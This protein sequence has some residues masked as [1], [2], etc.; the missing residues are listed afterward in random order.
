[1]SEPSRSLTR[2][3]REQRAYRLVLTTA[4]L[5]LLT[6]LAVIAAIIGI[7]GGGVA[8]VGAL[9]TGASG[10]ALRKTLNPGR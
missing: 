4:T 5:A 6:V 8:V 1:M 7:V 10:Y 2:R 3:Q 9:A